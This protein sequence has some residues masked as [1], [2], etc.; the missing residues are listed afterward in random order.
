[1]DR[2]TRSINGHMVTCLA[3]ECE[4][5]NFGPMETAKM[6]AEE[7]GGDTGQPVEIDIKPG[8]PEWEALKNSSKK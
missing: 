2:M 3:D 8:N 6:L 5:M 4:W 7:H 1:M